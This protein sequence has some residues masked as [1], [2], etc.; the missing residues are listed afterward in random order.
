[1]NIVPAKV[2]QVLADESGATIV[3]YGVLVLGVIAL[4]TFAMTQ[5]KGSL[6]G[7]FTKINTAITNVDPTGGSSSGG[8]GN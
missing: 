5:M 7:L 1:M 8:T 4:A 6:E 2:R 3:E